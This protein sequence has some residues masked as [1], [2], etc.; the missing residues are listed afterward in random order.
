MRGYLACP[1]LWTLPGQAESFCDA[2][3]S[4]RRARE[5]LVNVAHIQA[6]GVSTPELNEKSAELRRLVN[7]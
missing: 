4:R 3:A 7:E 5:A 6:L 1:K 2:E